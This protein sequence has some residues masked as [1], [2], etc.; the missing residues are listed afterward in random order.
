MI[1]KYF[2]VFYY[3]IF[4]LMWITLPLNY[5]LKFTTDDSYF[6]IK[7]ALNFANEF[8]SSFDTLNSTN[9][10]HPLWFILLAFI[11]KI[12]ITLKI[13][14]EID[15]FRIVFLLTTIINYFTLKFVYKTFKEFY[16]NDENKIFLSASFLLIPLVLFYLIGMEVQI[17]LLCF[18][19]LIY[20]LHKFFSEQIQNSLKVKISILLSLIFL[21]RVDL[22]WYVFI[23]ITLYILINKKYLL[24]DWIKI[25]VVPFFVFVSYILLNKNYF[26]TFYPISSLYKFSLNI[27][28]NLKN[29]PNPF[30][31]PIDFGI[32]LLNIFFLLIS[33]LKF[34]N[35][36]LKLIN[37][38]KLLLYFSLGIFSFLIINFLV[39]SNG[40][41]EWYYSYSLFC[42]ILIYLITAQQTTKYNQIIFLLLVIFNLFYF[43]IFRM[44]Y[45]NHE[46]AYKYA[47][48]IHQIVSSED[49]IY[50]VDYSG[51]VSFFS[52]KKIINGD[53]LINSFEYYNYVKNGELDRYLEKIKPKYLSFYSFDNPILNDTI[54][55]EFK[56]FKNYS[57]LI[58]SENLVIKEPFLY[59]GIFRRKVGF[60]YLV[61]FN[62]YKI[63]LK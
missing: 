3:F 33:F 40:V 17:F 38:F 6:Y 13:T 63:V 48:K 9:G 51:I 2:F 30:S 43:T 23:I 58:P 29:V 47:Q 27:F 10:Y 14:N 37:S 18:I 20:L 44:N 59:G 1:K 55:Y 57:I 19:S 56:L 62:G 24:L 22:F 42:A 54:K 26:N 25:S 7:T 11:F 41:R 16:T 60:F 53:G 52:G 28:E 32:L 15:L 36:K 4:F 49:F 39:N 34:S 45:Y 12:A 21:S 46:S 31:N 35:S 8:K 5:L 61:R 50:Q